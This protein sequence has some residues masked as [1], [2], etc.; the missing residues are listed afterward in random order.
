M[1]GIQRKIVYVLSFELLAIAL[2]ST[3]L[4][5]LSDTGVVLAGA[6]AVGCSV[7]AMLWNL[8][9]NALFEAWE[10]RQARKG[11]SHQRPASHT[12][13]L[14]ARHVSHLVPQLAAVLGVTWGEALV[15]NLAMVL[16]FLA[17]G[18]LF[19]LAFDRLFGL[20][21]AAQPRPA[22]SEARR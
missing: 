4:R 20:P 10:A 2:S 16:F 7:I 21:L 9:Y 12:V 19:N 14:E 1:Q 22:D 8:A 17:Y 18:F 13:G 15:L 5:L 3:L 11:R 6:L